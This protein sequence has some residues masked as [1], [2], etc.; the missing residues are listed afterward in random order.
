[1]P[2]DHR[3][4]LS[5]LQPTLFSPQHDR[6]FVLG[7]SAAIII[8]RWISLGL[9]VFH[10]H[11]GNQIFDSPLR[12]TDKSRISQASL[13]PWTLPSL[14]IV[15]AGSN[16]ATGALFLAHSSPKRPGRKG[17]QRRFSREW[18]AKLHPLACTDPLIPS[19]WMTLIPM[20]GSSCLFLG[21]LRGCT[22]SPTPTP[23]AWP[24]RFGNQ[25]HTYQPQPCGETARYQR[26]G[27]TYPPRST[28]PRRHRPKVR[29]PADPR[30]MVARL[31][32][33]RS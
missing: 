4:H 8:R 16:C 31:H 30:P 33:D 19:C 28:S 18:Q 20:P 9:V 1:M 17:N 7:L 26:F 32:D 14:F 29:P 2:S 10:R 21:A 23:S 25:P 13:Q 3:C 6:G 15:A 22:S 12:P 11:R 5:H 27:V 24:L